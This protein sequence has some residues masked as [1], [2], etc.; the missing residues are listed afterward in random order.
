MSMLEIIAV[1]LGLANIL[2]IVR[3][4]LWNY[5]FGI[6]MVTLYFFIFL[7]AKLYS[8]ALLQV[9]F[10]ALNLYG[11]RHWRRAQQSEGVPV[12]WLGLPALLGWAGAGLAASLLWGLLM[13]RGTDAAAPYWD[14]SIAIYSV[15]AQLLMARRYVDNWLGWILVDAL[16]VPLYWSKGL[17]LTAGLYALFLLIS[18]AGLLEWMRARRRKAAPA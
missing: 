9:F 18:C 11:W 14:A 7:D 4:S 17:E 6:A 5:P 12:R 3:R 1:I 10:L 16:A 13:Q 2:L 15:L 8:D